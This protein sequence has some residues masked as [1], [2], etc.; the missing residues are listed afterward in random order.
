MASEGVEIGIL[1]AEVGKFS[2]GPPTVLICYC[3]R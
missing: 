1:L 3:P 2:L